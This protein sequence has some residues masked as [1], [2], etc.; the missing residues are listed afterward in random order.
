MR[1]NLLQSLKSLLLASLLVFSSCGYHTVSSDDKTTI[2]IPYV[3]G[4]AQGQLTSELIRQVTNSNLYRFVKSDGEVCL[5]VAIV[6]DKS[7]IV[8]FQYD[9]TSKKGK[10][11]RNLMP[12][13]NRRTI[14]AQVTLTDALT[15]EVIVGPVNVK[16]STDYDYIDVNS[17]KEVSFVDEQGKRQK[18]ITYSLGQLDSIEG[19]EDAALT[20]IYRQLAQKITQVLSKKLL[21][22][23]SKK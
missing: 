6:N 10:I 5:R 22:D 23:S 7:D 17:L 19:A 18:T 2:S 9:L 13:E 4:D 11:E 20:P 8:G 15:Q 16:V 1:S 3:E 12:E 14:T 21:G